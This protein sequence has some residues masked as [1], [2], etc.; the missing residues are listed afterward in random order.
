M[1]IELIKSEPHADEQRRIIRMLVDVRALEHLL[2]RA[3][4]RSVYGE[5]EQIRDTLSQMLDRADGKFS[6]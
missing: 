2:T 4:V 3:Q 6:R 1:T 5:L